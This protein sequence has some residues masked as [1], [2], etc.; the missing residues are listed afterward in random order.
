MQSSKLSEKGTKKRYY[1]YQCRVDFM[2]KSKTIPKP[3]RQFPELE[4]FFISLST[5][6]PK[7][8]EGIKI[9]RR[10]ELDSVLF[11]TF[12][13]INMHEFRSTLPAYICRCLSQP[14]GPSPLSFPPLRRASPHPPSPA[15]I[16][17]PLNRIARRSTIL[18][19]F[20][21]NANRLKGDPPPT[22]SCI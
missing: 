10:S 8:K 7:E 9:S 16:P 3:N 13:L 21:S 20:S 15:R 2:A 12:I 22:D 1:F 19:F 14:L 18:C 4:V 6:I 11:K 17:P 5:H